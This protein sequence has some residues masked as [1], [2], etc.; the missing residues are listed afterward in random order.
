MAACLKADRAQLQKLLLKINGSVAAADS[1]CIALEN[2]CVCASRWRVLSAERFA[3]RTQ[4]LS[5]HRGW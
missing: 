1:V 3:R 5:I 2:G 4:A